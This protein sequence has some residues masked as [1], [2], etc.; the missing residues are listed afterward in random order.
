MNAFVSRADHI[1]R[2]RLAATPGALARSCV[3]AGC[4]MALAAAGP[5]LPF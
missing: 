1:V 4:A 2:S 5:F 3:I